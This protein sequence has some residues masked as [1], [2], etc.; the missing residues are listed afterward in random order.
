MEDDNPRVSV[1]IPNYN[2]GRFLAKRLHSVLNQTYHDFEVIYL[3]DAS[4][5]NSNEVFSRFA[6]EKRVRAYFNQKNSGSPFRQWNKG[7]KLARGEYIWIAESDD[8]ADERFLER[9]VPQLNK[10]PDVGLAF[11]KSWKVDE[12]GSIV[13]AWEEWVAEGHSERWKRDFVTNGQEECRRQLIVGNTVPNASSTL[14]RRSVYEKAGCAD[15]TMKVCG[16]WLMWLKMLMISDA[17]FVA[18]PLNYFRTHPNTV[19]RETFTNGVRIEEDYKVISYILAS[20]DISPAIA[21]RV[22]EKMATKWV[23]TMVSRAGW[24][25]WGH[26]RRIYRI[27]CNMDPRL[28]TRLV[29]NT[30]FR[31]IRAVAR[32]RTKTDKIAKTHNEQ[33]YGFA[34]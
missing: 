32:R 13:A 31:L 15:E 9:L 28:R 14:I 24:I 2:H 10:N 7:V 18:T 16:D 21:E 3:D 19:R 22:R 8:F 5:D 27:A 6:G 20:L 30:C 4:T 17:A 34:R 25:G 26:N 11:C 23:N 29:K 12:S 33:K 1:I